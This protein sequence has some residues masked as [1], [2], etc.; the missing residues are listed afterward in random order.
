M[1]HHC[2]EQVQDAAMVFLKHCLD[3]AIF[4]FSL[5]HGVVVVVHHMSYTFIQYAV[6]YHVLVCM[7]L[8]VVIC[9]V[10]PLHELGEPVLDCTTSIVWIKPC[11]WFMQSLQHAHL[12]YVL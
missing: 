12:H 2:I 8:G 6:W 4:H 11:V 7:W 10:P 3:E 1:A 9:H 5:L